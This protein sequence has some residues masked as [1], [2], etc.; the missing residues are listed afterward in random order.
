TPVSTNTSVAKPSY[1]SINF[2]QFCIGINASAGT[3]NPFST[4]SNGK[5]T[6]ANVLGISWLSL[7]SANAR[8]RNVRVAVSTK[9]SMAYSL[10]VNSSLVPCTVNRT[11]VPIFTLVAY[12]SGIENS[13]FTL[14]TSTS[15]AI[16]VV[17]VI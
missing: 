2:L 4:V 8:T 6:L 13:S 12:L 3:N 14:L 9:G 16:S 7:L 1:L 17:G 11:G 5:I 15:W 10:A